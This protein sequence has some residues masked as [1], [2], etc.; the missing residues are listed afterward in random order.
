MYGLATPDHNGDAMNI[1]RYGQSMG[2]TDD[3]WL[4]G[5]VA[6]VTGAASGIGRSV[7]ARLLRGGARVA[8]IDRDGDQLSRSFEDLRSEYPDS[9]FLTQ[10]VDVQSVAAIDGA[11]EAI[12]REFSGLDFL[13]N[14]AGVLQSKPFLEI[15]QNDWDHIVNVSLR[16]SF[17]CMQAA[18]RLMRSGGS[19]VNISSTAAR[20]PS[21]HQMHYAAAKMGVISI[22]RSAAVA[23][24]PAIRVNAICPGLVD[25]PMWL[26]AAQD[27]ETAVQEA[28]LKRSTTPDEM[29]GVVVFLLSDAAAYITGQTWDANGGL[30]MS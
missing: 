29:A 26:A 6:A 20:R 3:Q 18:A 19:I 30:S 9:K 25:T 13:V 2:L 28:P 27:L 4:A 16:G 15:T 8:A 17:F 11:F 1:E 24:A 14:S 23:L 5:R 21:P 12:D 10:T 22:T 7:A